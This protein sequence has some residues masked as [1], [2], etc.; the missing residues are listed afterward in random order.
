MTK[1]DMDSRVPVTVLT[2]FLGSGKTTLVNRI[3]TEN[4]GKRIAVVE[5]EYNE[6]SIDRDL[7]VSEAEEIVEMNNGCLCCMVRGDLMV[8]LRNLL[9]R[10]EKFDYI[11]IETSG[12]TDPGP[13]AQTFIMDDYLK[14]KVRLDG[15][16]TLVDSKH[17]WLHIDEREELR[18]QIA[19]AD[20]VLL[21]KTDLASE[22]ELSKLEDHLRDINTLA[23]IH[24]TQ[25]SVAKMEDI[26]DIRA[27]EIDRILST[28]PNLMVDEEDDCG[29]A[30]GITSVGITFKGE[31]DENKVEEWAHQLGHDRGAD[32]FRSKGVLS[33]KD[34]PDRVVFQGV[35]AIFDGQTDRPWGDDD[36]FNKVVFIGRNLEREELESGLRAC[37]ADE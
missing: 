36:R 8:A 30:E 18:E 35:H 1:P 3:L 11:L 10:A 15:I 4:H 7:V 29:I 34:V 25:N 32:I 26:L 33:F 22:L 2:G 16:V 28:H 23:K 13:V 17:V 27:F 31:L 14:E 12:L 6:L 19:F 24:R 9:K 20:V 21:N 5:N 37:I